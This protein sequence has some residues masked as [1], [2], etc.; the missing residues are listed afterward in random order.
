METWVNRKYGELDY[1]YDTVPGGT[2]R[3]QEKI[4]S[5][6]ESWTAASATIKKINER[7]RHIEKERRNIT[8]QL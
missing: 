4:M 6:Q 2:R 5:S 3:I 7:L 1:Q 8:T